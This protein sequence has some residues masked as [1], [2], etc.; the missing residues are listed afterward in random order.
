[1]ETQVNPSNIDGRAAAL[2]AAE[3]AAAAAKET[4]APVVPAPVT[5]PAEPVKP[6]EPVK[7]LEPKPVEPVKPEAK[8]PND[9][10]EMRKW[11]TKVAQENSAT[12]EEIKGLRLALEKLTKK[13][14]DY[15]ELAKD[16]E[17]IKKQIE[18]ERQEAVAEMEKQLHEA[19]N[20]ARKNE[21]IVERIRMEGDAT[22]YPEF[23]RVF[24]TMQ[25]LS[26]NSDGRINWNQ[27]VSDVLESLYAL[28][29]QLNPVI[30]APA[31][32]AP[33]TPAAPA[34]PVKSAE[35]IAAEQAALIAAAEK[36]GFEKAQEVMRA[37]Q[38]GGGIGSKGQGG[39]RSSGLSKEALAEMPL[40]EL[41]KLISKE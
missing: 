37:E 9:P 13:P 39:R 20:E 33:V 3:K 17:A 23:K 21:T 35:E 18:I 12:K 14:I 22:N 26:A 40:D 25:L 24:P 36:R 38:A 15:K 2:D 10:M 11:A 30:P 16:P 6:V 7:P 5:P 8:L 19:T 34:A 27:P 41:K 31:P 29:V 1:M 32:V 4:P 28:S